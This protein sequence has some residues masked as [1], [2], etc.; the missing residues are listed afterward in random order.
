VSVRNK[1]GREVIVNQA[2]WG[3]LVLGRIDFVFDGSGKKNQV[4]I[5]AN[6][7]G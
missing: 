7:M 3:G 6:Q 5:S 4:V 1:N 2:W